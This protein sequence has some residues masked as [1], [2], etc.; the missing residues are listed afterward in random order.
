MTLAPTHLVRRRP[1]VEE[2][3]KGNSTTP[4]CTCCYHENI[5]YQKYT[6]SA[7]AKMNNVADNSGF[8]LHVIIYIMLPAQLSAECDKMDVS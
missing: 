8:C 2:E 5:N 6:E 3:A 4:A 1:E 7:A